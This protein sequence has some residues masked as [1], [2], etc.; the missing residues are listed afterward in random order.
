MAAAVADYRPVVAGEHKIKK[1]G[2]SGLVLHLEQTPDILAG[3]V[4]G[5]RPGQT[6]VGFAAET[7]D[8]AATARAH[9][10][11][12]ARRKGADLL[13]FNEV[14]ATAGFG[15]VPN[16]VVILDAQG[17]EVARA[18]GT[19]AEVARAVVREIARHRSRLG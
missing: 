8:D 9:G 14:S 3:L 19:K 6:I 2:D 4:A 11:A 7:G 13:V 18:A 17:A 10:E 15:D 16:D 5:R 1:S 12:K